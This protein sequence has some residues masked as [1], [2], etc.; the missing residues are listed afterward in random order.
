MVS[1]LLTQEISGCAARVLKDAEVK[2]C[3]K[4]CMFL[5]Y[6]ESSMFVSQ[7]RFILKTCGRTTLLRAIK[8]L[9]QLVRDECGMDVIQVQVKSS[10]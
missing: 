1:C 6:S 9:L 7:N 3:C 2:T 8:P 4:S 5:C 10:L